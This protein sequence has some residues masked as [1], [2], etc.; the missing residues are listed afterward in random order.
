MESIRE[1][2]HQLQ[3]P[4]RSVDTWYGRH[5]MRAGSIFLTRIAIERG[6]TPNQITL[7]SLIAGILS[8]VFFSS[9]AWLF[10]ILFLNLWYLLDHVDGEVA[11]YTKASSNSGFFFDT[12][13]NFIV[14]PLIFLGIGCG[15]SGW[16][17]NPWLGLAVLAAFSSL[18]L[19]LIPMC[20]DSVIFISCRKAGKLPQA[21]PQAKTEAEPKDQPSL[22]RR[23]FSFWHLSITFPSVILSLTI[24]YAVSFLIGMPR[25]S[26]IQ[27][28]LCYYA[29]SVT[30]VWIAQLYHKIHSRKLDQVIF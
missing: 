2:R 11:R 18:F 4:R 29:V 17:A 6:L 24:F 21:A 23:F 3:D 27:I 8:A 9:Q 19:G 26:A 10:G 5:V 15:L 20:E 14:E 13:I 22:I 25:V 30:V 7:A 12:V 16:T 28:Y 1:L